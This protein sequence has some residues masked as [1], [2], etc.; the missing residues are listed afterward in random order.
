MYL[1]FQPLGLGL[2]KVLFDWNSVRSLTLVIFLAKL[3]NLEVFWGVDIGNAYLE[4]KAKENLY[5]VTGPE[6]KEL[7]GHILVIYK[8]LYMD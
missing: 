2:D 6:F 1:A 3:N 8:A 7:E 4:A 5:V